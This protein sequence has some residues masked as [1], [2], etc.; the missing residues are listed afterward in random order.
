MFDPS[1]SNALADKKD[2]AIL[3]DEALFDA[4]PVIRDRA[5]Q[6]L[7]E[8]VEPG[9]LLKVIDA[10]DAARDL[11]RRRALRILSSCPPKHT[12]KHLKNVL[13]DDT[14]SPRIRAA[15]ARILT[16]TSDGEI[17]EFAHALK[18]EN[19]KVRRA[20][21]TASAPK[22]ALIDALFDVDIDLVDRAA[23]A[24]LKREVA[25]GPN[26]LKKM[27]STV[28]QPADQLV[29]LIA[30]SNAESPL[31]AR[32]AE[33]GVTAAYDYSTSA[34]TLEDK[35]ALKTW[36]L[37]K[38]GL[39]E[40]LKENF[41]DVQVRASMARHLAHD[42]PL[43]HELAKDPESTVAWFAQQNLAGLYN[44]AMVGQRF[45]RNPIQLSPSS[46]AP[47]GLRAED[48]LLK[49]NRVDACL[50]L[51][52]A[53]FNMNLGVAMRSAEAAGIR[54][55]M[56]VGRGDFLRNPA[57]GADLAIDVSTCADAASLITFARENN[58]QIVAIQQTASSI[59]YHLA[60]YPPR[61]L[62]VVGSEDAGMPRQLKKA[63]DLVVEIPQYGLIDSL[64]VAT[65][66]TVVLFH[67]RVNFGSG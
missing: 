56:F 8:Q 15:V 35:P 13:L 14:K 10:L 36:A 22:D 61:P 34:K 9:W 54:Q 2:S 39:F 1:L 65:A 57:R 63:A 29:R 3:L 24:L 47:Y 11:T 4:N 30:F 33:R 62:F 58:Y 6:I 38:Q 49:T 21:A 45:E 66:A 28:C 42:D 31:L 55:V 19:L 53:R 12:H 25:L 64:N 37:A 46:Q 18:T 26:V 50:A 51:H 27:E 41:D 20:V 40:T 67:W 16:A 48:T 59:P 23:G 44:D 43:L 7:A 52:Q 17:I 60:S 32:F 5:N